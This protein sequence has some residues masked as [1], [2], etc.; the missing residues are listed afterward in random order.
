MS[1]GVNGSDR[2]S[3]VGEEITLHYLT[4]QSSIRIV[5]NFYLFNYL[6]EKNILLVFSGHDCLHICKL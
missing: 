4:F 5:L 1:T 6:Q 3:T 2:L